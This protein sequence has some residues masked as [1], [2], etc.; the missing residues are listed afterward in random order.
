MLFRGV[1]FMETKVHELGQDQL[2]RALVDEKLTF[3]A[4]NQLSGKLA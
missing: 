2:V 4:F 1:Y 3:A